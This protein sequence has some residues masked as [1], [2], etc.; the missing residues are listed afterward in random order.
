MIPRI[1]HP[2][3]HSTEALP[4]VPV[5]VQSGRILWSTAGHV[6]V[7]TSS[8]SIL[9]VAFNALYAPAECSLQRI[10][11]VSYDSID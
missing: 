4:L 1:Y 11:C 3:W 8:D 2:R 10:S 6:T 9:Q 7:G 5:G